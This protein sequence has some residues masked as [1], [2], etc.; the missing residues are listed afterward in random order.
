MSFNYIN[1][2]HNYLVIFWQ[3]VLLNYTILRI[4][5]SYNR[6][7]RFDNKLKSGRPKKNTHQ[8]L[9]NLRQELLSK[10]LKQKLVLEQFRDFYLKPRYLVNARLKKRLFKK[11]N[12]HVRL[13]FARR[14][15]NWIVQD[16]AKVLFNHKSC[17]KTL[18]SNGINTKFDPKC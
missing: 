6:R 14:N 12:R 5:W 16:W 13:E 1:L 2:L 11:E 15:L 8:I 3:F 4:F 9:E 18:N 17:Y 10:F 7:G